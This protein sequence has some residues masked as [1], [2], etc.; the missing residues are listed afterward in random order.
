[1]KQEIKKKIYILIMF[2]FLPFMIVPV[3]A[4]DTS[5]ISISI[6]SNKEITVDGVKPYTNTSEVENSKKQQ[7]TAMGKKFEK[8]NNLLTFIT[9][10]ATITMLGIFI[11]NIIHFATLGTE[12]WI[13]KRQAMFGL[14]W[15]GIATAL[16]GSATLWMA[17]SYGLFK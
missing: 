1:M 12:H 16:L 11:K 6:G 13:L 8:M 4:I 2:L 7:T 15:T 9:G 3:N 5:N 17:L 14:L 10:I